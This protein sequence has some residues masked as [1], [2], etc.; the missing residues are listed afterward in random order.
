MQTYPKFKLGA[1]I[2][3]EQQ[4]FFDQHGFL[5]FEQVWS[6]DEMKKIVDALEAI[7][8]KVLNEKIMQVQGVPVI[9]GYDENNHPVAQRTPFTNKL[10]PVIHEMAYSEKLKPL[11]QV[12]PNSRIGVEERDGVVYSHYVK[13]RGSRYKFL[14]W[15]TDSLRDWFY[16][17]RVKPMLNVGIHITSTKK[18][19]GGLRVLPGTHIQSAWGILFRKPY[20]I[21]NRPDPREV[22]VETTMGDVTIHDGRMWHRAD[23]P[24][25]KIQGHRRVMYFPILTG[26][27]APKN[28][29]SKAPIYLK[30]KRTINPYAKK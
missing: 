20:F 12:L 6:S 1:T 24:T 16:L 7:D 29:Q 22:A 5:H 23:S 14:G 27:Y 17:E 13:S 2:T 21:Y 26:R 9:Y 18:E 25:Q 3:P 8:Q 30:L 28:A 10:S 11:L 4:A 15:H 19:N